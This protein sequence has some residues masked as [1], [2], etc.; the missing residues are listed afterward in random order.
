MLSLC[1]RLQHLHS[2]ILKVKQNRETLYVTS[3]HWSFKFDVPNRLHSGDDKKY[4]AIDFIDKSDQES[5][6][7]KPAFSIV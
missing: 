6:L 2:N 3:L 5:V 4:Y 7:F 1:L